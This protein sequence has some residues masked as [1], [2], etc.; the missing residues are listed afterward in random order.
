VSDHEGL[1]QV[2]LSA[3]MGPATELKLTPPRDYESAWGT[4]ERTSWIL[5]ISNRRGMAPM[6][7]LHVQDP[8]VLWELHDLIRAALSPR[9][10]E[11]GSDEQ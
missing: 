3:F 5:Q 9:T 6:V 10:T 1:H 7:T 11:G 4:T 2:S 8:A